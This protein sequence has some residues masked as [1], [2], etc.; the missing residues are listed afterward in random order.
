MVLIFLFDIA[1]L[2]FTVSCLLCSQN[3]VNITMAA[4]A[5]D[6]DKYVLITGGAGY[7]GTH[8]VVECI[9]AGYKVL[10][11]DNFSNSCPGKF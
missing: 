8:C 5:P 9:A 1:H 11:L 3:S 10:V 4:A 2:T 7:I 6:E